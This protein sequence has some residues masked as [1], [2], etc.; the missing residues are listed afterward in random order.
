MKASGDVIQVGPLTLDTP[1]KATVTVIITRD[2][3]GT[4]ICHVERTGF[5]SLS[6]PKP[7]D[8]KIDWPVRACVPVLLCLVFV[9]LLFFLSFFFFS[10][11]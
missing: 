7:G 5:A 2:R 4:E 8:E 11:E 10:I 9:Q 3:D 6:D 1:G